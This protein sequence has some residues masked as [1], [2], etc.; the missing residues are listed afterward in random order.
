MEGVEL[1]GGEFSNKNTVKKGA[2]K[3]PRILVCR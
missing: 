3:W 1:G 2:V